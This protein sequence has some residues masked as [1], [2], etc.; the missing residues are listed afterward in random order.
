MQTV[1]DGFE[2][3]YG[4]S[5]TGGNA[6]DTTIKRSGAA[7]YKI[8]ASA[9]DSNFL[10]RYVRATDGV[11]YTQ[12]WVYFTAWPASDLGVLQYLDATDST[13]RATLSV[14]STGTVKLKRGNNAAA[15]IGSASSAMS[16]NTWHC[17]AIKC[18]DGH[19]SAEIE[20]KLDDTVFA[21]ETNAATFNSGVIYF[22]SC[23]NVA[24]AVF[25]IDDLVVNDNT[26]SVN[27]GYPAMTTKLVLALPT[28]A[29]DSAAT[30]G[31]FSYIN[32][33]PPTTTATSGSTMI[34]LDNNPT[35]AEYAMTDSGTL[36]IGSSD[37]IQCVD[38]RTFIRE[39]AAGAS[40]YAKRIK[41][42]ASGTVTETSF[43][44]A[45]NATARMDPV[46]SF[47]HLLPLISETDPT[48]GVAWTPTGTNSIDNMQCGVK[49]TDGTPDIWCLWMGAYIAFVPASGTAHTKTLTDVV[50]PVD[51]VLKTPARTLTDV[52]TLVATTLKLPS[53]TLSEVSTMVDTVLK[54]G[55]RILSEAVTPVD[56][57]ES[58]IP[59]K[60]LFEAITVVDTFIRSVSRILTEA[61]TPVASFLQQAARTLLE[62]VTPVDV[63]SKTPGR[64]L[65]D[66]MVL[67]DTVI[68]KITA[69]ILTEAIALVDTFSSKFT[70]KVFLETV[71]VVDTFLHQVART[72]TESII[73]VASILNQAGKVLSDALIPVDTFVRNLSRTL[74]D[75]VTPVATVLNQG[76]RTLTEALFLVDSVL[77]QAGKVLSDP[78]ALVDTFIRTASRTLAETVTLVSTV[79]AP[80]TA[81]FTETLTLVASIIKSPGKLLSDSFSLVSAFT[82]LVNGVV[83][84]WTRVLRSATSFTRT[85]RPES[86]PS[87]T[88]RPAGGF[89]REDRPTL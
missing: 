67:V 38:L 5:G 11:L 58:K 56:T 86:T 30:T 63:L 9:T 59:A 87:R 12:L 26:G 88:A 57:F 89:N 76:S 25:Y 44:D 81:T 14:S 47:S 13:W 42:A 37:T 79:L 51:T 16:L 45:G 36:G 35:T 6:I 50:T 71:A 53:R 60:I 65:T 41:S 55:G 17:L 20:A 8:T 85:D 2:T 27:N 23:D 52:I 1:A 3:T 24:S 62:V 15:Q 72:L 46:G 68:S 10:V 80:Y 64:V 69:R 22:G 28:G 39:E 66:A 29:G 40:N 84:R 33:I 18:E 4:Y 34:E 54:Q 61:V 77:K 75:V 74:I 73:L 43:N 32:E 82:R 49:T 48:T 19:G 7:S 83:P 70:A 78:V 31:V 21:S